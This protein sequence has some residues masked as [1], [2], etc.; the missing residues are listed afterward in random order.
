M[1]KAIIL[2]YHGTR[3]KERSGKLYRETE[4]YFSEKFLDAKV[5]SGIDS[6]FVIKKLKEEGESSVKSTDEV[7]EELWESGYEKVYIQPMYLLQGKILREREQK[8]FQYRQRFK[9]IKILPPL[10]GEIPHIKEFA[11]ILMGKFHG[12]N[13]GYLLIG[14]G[15]KDIGNCALGM[16]GYLLSIQKDNFFL[17]TLEEGIELEKVMKLMLKKSYSKI[18]IVPLLAQCGMHFNEDIKRI[19]FE[20]EG[21]GIKSEVKE[22]TLF[23]Y[24]EVLNIL[25]KRLK[26]EIGTD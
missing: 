16:L 22:K 14:H 10:L 26:E 23:Q 13:E 21:R 24:M 15:G 25:E 17:S 7:L 4:R 19:S 18:V 12:K 9:E 20:L 8:N 3:E 2:S 5:M 6:D 11:E 1:K